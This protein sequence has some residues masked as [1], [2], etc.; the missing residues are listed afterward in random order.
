MTNQTIENLLNY[1]LDTETTSEITFTETIRSNEERFLIAHIK[2]WEVI[3]LRKLKEL[4]QN[5]VVTMAK[6]DGDGQ[7]AANAASGDDES[8]SSDNE[9][10]EDEDGAADKEQ[11]A[12]Q[13]PIGNQRVG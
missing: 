3:V 13:N 5:V 4:H 10:G 11:E 9:E 6:V 7:Q 1:L 2:E 8:G 12:E